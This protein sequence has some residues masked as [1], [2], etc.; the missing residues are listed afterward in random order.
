MR[1]QFT[2]LTF[3]DP[4]K[5]VVH[6]PATLLAMGAGGM[7]GAASVLGP[8]LSVFGAISE[9][10]AANE[11]AAEHKREATEARVAGHQ[12]AQQQR[13]ASRQRI[14]RDRAAQI[15]GGAYSGTAL[16]LESQNVAAMELDALMLEYRGEQAG[17]AADAR[18][19]QAKRS[20]SPLKIFTAAVDGFTNFDPLNLAPGGGASSRSYAT[21]GNRVYGGGR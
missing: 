17:K 13:K 3:L 8:V 16:G 21:V 18:A 12:E 15:E 7:G 14:A 19:E 1:G 2:G 5:G 9:V 6:D 4:M 11:Q 20:A 10:Q